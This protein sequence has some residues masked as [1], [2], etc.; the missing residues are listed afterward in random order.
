VAVHPGTQI[1][2]SRLAC[3]TS[4]ENA[5]GGSLNGERRVGGAFR[6]DGVAVAASGMVEGA[7]GGTD[8]QAVSRSANAAPTARASRFESSGTTWPTR[9][10]ACRPTRRAKRSESRVSGE[11]RIQLA[12]P[13][14]QLVCRVVHPVRI[15]RVTL[16]QDPADEGSNP[17]VARD[18]RAC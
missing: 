14:I 7:S 3:V 1:V 5:P 4:A 18:H 17:V 9:G 12:H 13:E 8:A 10:R 15:G 6:S 2:L 11:L 16:P